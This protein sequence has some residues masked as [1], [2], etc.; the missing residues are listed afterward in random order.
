M[1]K[2]TVIADPYLQ[3]YSFL[4]YE[5]TIVAQCTALAKAVYTTRE[6]ALYQKLFDRYYPACSSPEND[7]L[8]RK[9]S[10][11]I[12]EDIL[13][14]QFFCGPH[15]RHNLSLLF[16]AELHQNCHLNLEGFFRFRLPEYPDYLEIMLGYATDSL[17]AEEEQAEYIT[18]LQNFLQHGAPNPTGG[19]L[20][21]F[22]HRDNI[23]H[24]C[25]VSQGKLTPLEGGRLNG[26]EDVLIT[27]LLLLCPSKLFVHTSEEQPVYTL[28]SLQEIFSEKIVI[29]R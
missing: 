23:Y 19:E 5:D 15:R 14:N 12:E 13:H 4:P 21:L 3:N 29:C 26:F 17:L 28:L 20:H 8:L 2:I 16:Q 24:I 9:A 27:N 6:Q 10:V 22:F 11:L 1:E 25:T 7:A 18:L